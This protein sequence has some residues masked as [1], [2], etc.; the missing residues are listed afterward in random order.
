MLDDIHHTV[1]P[2]YPI[3]TRPDDTIIAVPT[4]MYVVKLGIPKE[5]AFH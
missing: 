2:S 3:K 1:H 4:L 5:V